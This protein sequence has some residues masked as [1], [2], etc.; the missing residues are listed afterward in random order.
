M[1]KKNDSHFF[2]SI[3]SLIIFGILVKLKIGHHCH[4]GVCERTGKDLDQKLK[5][6]ITALDTVTQ[7]VH[8]ALKRAV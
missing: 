3:C 4:K 6:W 5:K 2:R 7:F 1:N 8:H